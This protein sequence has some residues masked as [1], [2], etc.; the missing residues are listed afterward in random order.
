MSMEEY[1]SY[2]HGPYFHWLFPVIQHYLSKSAL[3]S[4]YVTIFFLKEHQD[5][6]SDPK[7]TQCGIEWKQKAKT[8]RKDKK[9]STWSIHT[10]F[11][12]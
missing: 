4:T 7:S 9:Q 8:Q 12:K 10:I 1:T 6:I 2:L 11:C 5:K 3:F